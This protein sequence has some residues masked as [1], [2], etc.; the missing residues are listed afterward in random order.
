M[1]LA[2]QRAQFTW[3]LNQYNKS[4]DPAEQAR[5]ARAMA[6]RLKTAE[7]LG[8]THDAIINGKSYPADEVKRHLDDPNLVAEP[9]Y[10]KTT[11]SNPSANLW[12]QKE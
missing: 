2:G 11:R 6:Y 7:R 5:Y 8:F 9:E 1:S 12:T 10:L 3:A 4:D